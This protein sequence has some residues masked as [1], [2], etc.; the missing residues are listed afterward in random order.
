MVDIATSVDSVWQQYIISYIPI[1]ANPFIQAGFI[2]LVFIFG[3]KVLTLILERYVL[4]LA[5]KTKSDIDDKIL[6]TVKGPITWFIIVIGLKS[7][8]LPL[9]LGGTLH[10]ALQ[11]IFSSIMV[12][13]IAHIFIAIITILIGSWGK[14]VSAKTKSD[15]DDQ[16]VNLFTKTVRVVGYILAVLFILQVWGIQ[17]GPLLATLGVGGIAIAFALQNSLGNI[18]GGISMILDKT[19]KVGDRVQ[20]D[21]GT[22]GDVVDVGLRSTRIKT[23][24]NDMI[25]I[26]NGKLAEMKIQN[27]VFIN[28]NERHVRGNVDFGVEYGSDIDQ[29]EKVVNNALSNIPQIL[30][31]P[32]T[33]CVFMRMGDFA[34]EMRARYWVTDI[35]ARDD[36]RAQATKAVYNALRKAKIG[37]PYPTRTLYIKK[38]E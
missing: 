9:E 16:L 28:G 11:K 1:L 26:P 21:D 4:R 36:T 17:V 32:A 37:I 29:V 22:T 31:Q 38:E 34:L 23:T 6:A 13:I 27:Y 24:N 25:V 8:L 14:K 3:S 18:F 30:T 20:L 5:A 35:S 33:D 19:V 10:Q 7:A 15:V 12:L 2:L